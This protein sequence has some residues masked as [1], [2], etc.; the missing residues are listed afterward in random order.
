MEASTGVI[1]EQRGCS[2]LSSD[3]WKQL[4]IAKH[5]CV[6]VR[7]C[8]RTYVR[9]GVLVGKCQHETSFQPRYSRSQASSHCFK[10]TFS[11]PSSLSSYPSAK[12]HSLSSS[13]TPLPDT[14]SPSHQGAQSAS[15]LR[16]RP[17]HTSHHSNK[18][19]PQGNNAG[20]QTV[21]EQ[22]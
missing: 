21:A 16:F 9:V 18:G 2:G 1:K 6:F 4:R 22:S 3:A 5:I 20:S 14:H 13:F 15:A 8:V 10:V 12:S 17:H 7:A 19:V 11:P